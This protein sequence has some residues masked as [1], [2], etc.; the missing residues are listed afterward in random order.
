MSFQEINA[1]LDQLTKSIMLKTNEM[2]S[3]R[4]AYLTAKA[5]Y[6]FTMAGVKLSAKAMNPDATQ[7]DLDA[8][9]ISKGHAA[10]MDSIKAECAYKR[11]S[12]EIRAYRDRLESAREV[13]F[14]LRAERKI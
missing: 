6:D 4:E 8:E 3:A 12:N 7:T 10:R 13:A 2:E 5:N 14:N 11:L 1:E 9:A